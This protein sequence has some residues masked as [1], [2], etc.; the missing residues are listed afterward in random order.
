MKVNP[1][2]GVPS[3][4]CIYELH[5]AEMDLIGSNCQRV[6]SDCYCDCGTVKGKA[7]CGIINSGDPGSRYL[8]KETSVLQF[9]GVKRVASCKQYSY[10][11]SKG[12]LLRLSSSEMALLWSLNF[13]RA[14]SL[15]LLF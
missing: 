6:Y 11:P 2:E 13:Y 4:S 3:A 8:R 12:V 14:A 10:T 1:L 9:D 15:V 5:M 7:T